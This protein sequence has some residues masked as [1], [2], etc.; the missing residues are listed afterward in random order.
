VDTGVP[1]ELAVTDLLSLPNRLHATNA[2]RARRWIFFIASAL[3]TCATPSLVRAQSQTVT[4]TWD[5]NTD[6]LTTGYRLYYGT[7]SG[8]YTQNVNVGNVVSYPL[9]LASGTYFLVV[10]GYNASGQLGSSS[11]EVSITIGTTPPTASLTGTLVGANTASLSWTTS[12]ATSVTLNGASVALSGSAQYTISSATT[13]TLVA[14]GPGGSVTRSTTVSPVPPPTALFTGTLSGN[15]VADLSWQTTNATQVTIDGLPVALSGTAQYTIADTTTYTLVAS[16]PAGVVT[17]TVVVSPTPLDCV[18]SA[19]SL[20]STTTWTACEGGLQSRTETWTR[21]V[22]TE[23]QFGGAACGPLVEDRTVTQTCSAAPMPPGAP[24]GLAASVSSTTVTLSWGPNPDGGAPTGYYVSIGTSPG[25]S[26]VVNS[27]SVGNRLSASTSLSRGTYYARVRA[28]NAVGLSPDSAEV[29]FSIGAKSKP[30]RPGTL[31][32]SLSDGTATLTWTQPVAD[33]ASG[34]A[35]SGYVIEAGSGPGM[36]NV[37]T[38]WVANVTSYQA[39]GVPGGVYYVRV[40]AFNDEGLGEPSNEVVLQTSAP[41]G[42]P[43]NLDSS[44][45]G[46]IVQLTWQPPSSGNVVGY[47]IEAGSGPGLVNLASLHLGNQTSFATTAP[48]GTYYVRVRPVTAG[49]AM[50]PASN[51]IVVQR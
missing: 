38:V 8:T 45:A 12:N 35:P 2:R 42:P 22:L 14:T 36:A 7:A 48:P 4:A 44:G 32:G 16:G 43:L 49:G 28:E 10:R 37:A 30:R 6:G 15:N 11:N 9:T 21:T 5:A 27:A 50:G 47:V 17:Q 26:N 19:W 13:Y 29:T 24:V 34:D 39:V 3:L 25:A 51:E 18:V 1:L 41:S 31:S 46:S 20:Q 33:G 40:R 23:P